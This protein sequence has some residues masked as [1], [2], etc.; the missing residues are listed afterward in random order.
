MF[1]STSRTW[2]TPWGTS[3]KRRCHIIFFAEENLLYIVR[4]L[5]ENS[6][7]QSTF[8]GAKYFLSIELQSIFLK[9]FFHQQL[10][11]EPP[12]WVSLLTTTMLFLSFKILGIGVKNYELVKKCSSA[13]CFL[14]DSL[15]FFLISKKIF[16][17][18]TLYSL[19]SI[20][21][22]E[23]IMSQR[24][25]KSFKKIFPLTTWWI[26]S[27]PPCRRG[28]G[29]QHIPEVLKIIINRFPVKI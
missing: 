19:F 6:V 8:L 20:S 22:I 11:G 25:L 17:L 29:V 14:L 16:Y 21:P 13:S 9:K 24:Y 10:L 12:C 27:S 4:K 26:P 3:T 5:F 23:S 7:F 18:V 2:W 28:E 1:T 15:S